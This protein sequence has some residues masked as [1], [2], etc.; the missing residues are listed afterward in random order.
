MLSRRLL[1]GAAF[2]AVLAAAAPIPGPAKAEAVQRTSTT[3][4]V[5]FLEAGPRK[6]AVVVLLHPTDSAMWRG[7]FDALG[8][9]GFRVV[10][11][12]FPGLDLKGPSTGFAARAVRLQQLTSSLGLTRFHLVGTS[13]G[14]VLATQYAIAHP[15]QIRSLTVANSLAGLRD[16]A[17]NRIEA[18]L[19]SPQFDA[20]PR[21]WKELGP[22]YRALDAEGTARWIEMTE[23]ATPG[24]PAPALTSPPATIVVTWKALDDLNVPTLIV[25]GDADPYT[26]PG[27]LRLFTQRLKG[28][29]GV[30]IPDSGHAAYWENPTLFNRALIAFLRKH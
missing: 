4:G 18:R 19:R 14:G 15:D 1:Q 20:M 22:T 23:P 21:D 24:A 2:F 7:Q 13:G 6:G 16:E 28:S 3:T 5:A 30:V 10:A 9:A 27:I 17:F 26:P 12:D 25:T 11:V 8:S 29:Q